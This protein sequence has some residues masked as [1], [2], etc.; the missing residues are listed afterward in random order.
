MKIN[1]EIQPLV[2]DFERIKQ[3]ADNGSAFWS[4]RDL[5]TAMGYSTYQK[6]ERILKKA[7]ETASA[8]GLGEANHFNQTVEMVR[9]GSGSFRKVENCHLSREACLLV[10]ENADRKKPQV[11]MALRYFSQNDSA[12][13]TVQN[14]EISSIL[15]YKT[16]Q[17]ESRI[18]VIF[19]S[20]TFWMPQKRM[21]ELYGVDVRTISYHLGEIFQSGE[22]AEKSVLRKIGITA[23]DGK[24]YDTNVYN[25]DAIIAKN[26]L[27]EKEILKLNRLST[28]FLDFAETQAENHIVMNMADWQQQ[29]E[30]FLSVYNFDILQNAGTVSAEDA[31]QKAFAEYDKFKLVQDRDYLSDFDKEIKKLSETAT[32]N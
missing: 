17:G 12:V 18:E 31:K 16:S 24:V 8:K 11:Q 2:S 25:L 7:Q 32:Q 22:L 29:L 4:A 20:D 27:S 6:F 1:D 19:N 14:S 3:V 28:A 10:A 21:A 30:K 13:E 5:C 26:Y 9:L 23:A 15:L